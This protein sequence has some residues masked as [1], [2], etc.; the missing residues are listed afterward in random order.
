M[1]TGKDGKRH[2]EARY[3][4][5]YKDQVSVN[6][7]TEL[8]TSVIPGHAND[9]DGHKLK[10]LVEKDGGKGIKVGTVAGDKGY[11]DGENHYYLKERGIDSAIRL[12]NYRTQKKDGNKEGW[13]AFS[14]HPLQTGKIPLPQ[15]P[16]VLPLAQATSVG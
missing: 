11:D 2:K 10:K 5:G 8:V 12:N 4:Y 15:L 1:V 7:A 16:E 14:P 9:Y 13:L 6:A 3:F